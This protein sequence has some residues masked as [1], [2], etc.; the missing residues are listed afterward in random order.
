M[1]KWSILG[2]G[3][4]FFLLSACNNHDEIEV[5]QEPVNELIDEH[6]VPDTVDYVYQMLL[7]SLPAEL[8][9]VSQFAIKERQIFAATML[10]DTQ[11][12]LVVSV[13]LYGEPQVRTE[14]PLPNPRGFLIGPRRS[15]SGEV[16]LL[17]QT[18]R[19][20]V[21]GIR[22]EYQASL[23]RL[24]PAGDLLD[25]IV[26]E[27][28][29]GI[30]LI[31]DMQID[32][33]GRVYLLRYGAVASE[34][35]LYHKD[36][37]QQGSFSLDQW[38]QGLLSV[39]DRIYVGGW[40]EAIYALDPVAME[41]S[42][43][44][45]RHVHS[46]AHSS[47]G[48]RLYYTSFSHLYSQ[49]LV[50]GMSQEELRFPS[51]GIGSDEI[52]WIEVTGAGE[53]VVLLEGNRIA[54]LTRVSPD[55]IPP[56]REITL[57]TARPDTMLEISIAHFNME[58]QGY[59]IVLRDYSV[60]N[61]HED[62]TL[63]HRRLRED[64]LAG[65]AFDLLD[66]RGLPTELL[67]ARGLLRNLYTLIDGAC[68]IEREEIHPSVRAALEINGALYALP[69]S[70]QLVTLGGAADV[71]VLSQDIDPL[72]LLRMVT[73]LN[74]SELTDFTAGEARFDTDFFVSFLADTKTLVPVEFDTDRGAGLE[75]LR[76]T[77]FQ[78]MALY[79]ALYDGVAFVG[80]PSV[81]EPLHGMEFGRKFAI[82]AESDVPEMAWAFIRQQLVR[83]EERGLNFP[84]LWRDLDAELEAA[85]QSEETETWGFGA[86]LIEVGA[87]S[88]EEAQM[89]LDLIAETR[90]SLSIDEVI[91]AIIEEE[92][93]RFYMG[94]QSAEAAVR[95]MN[96]RVGALLG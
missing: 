47:V 58:H 49:D 83:E 62:W 46:L 2:I 6:P 15:A 27:D 33:E 9:D 5:L 48:A 51:V 34:V 96:Q 3:L 42:D 63:G 40:G 7:F 16:F 12:A 68:A 61:T 82:S 79:N 43:R 41:I 54:V 80:F 90:T 18:H 8:S 29:D 24:S 45:Q 75:V 19:E 4:L 89:V 10:Y 95:A 81:G 64:I 20:I 14:I 88:P 17:A 13:D 87:V 57:A 76:V 50:S 92:A 52:R 39:E 60:Y 55:E 66:V 72:S 67:A 78:V 93:E 74:W 53:V 86:H 94:V 38:A 91:W 22:E 73:A 26:L 56:V 11:A 30:S 59:Q 23:M 37:T 77:G 44:T 84:I 69:D 65:A 71:S 85:M 70:F 21:D 31:S 1:R 28:L 25:T 36:G 32:A 35:L